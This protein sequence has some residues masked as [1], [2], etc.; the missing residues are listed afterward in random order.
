MLCML[1][2][3][4]GARLKARGGVKAAMPRWGGKRATEEDGGICRREGCC[5]RG[6]E[7]VGWEGGKGE[8]IGMSALIQIGR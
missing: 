5:G 7:G 4:E 1:R 8:E 3:R 2:G 6:W